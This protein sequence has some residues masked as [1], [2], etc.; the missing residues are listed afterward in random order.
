MS[1]LRLRWLAC[2]PIVA[3]LTATACEESGIVIGKKPGQSQDGSGG[4][5]APAPPTPEP[6]T[7]DDGGPPIADPGEP[8][9]PVTGCEEL[10]WVGE[11][12]EVDGNGGPIRGPG[13][14]PLSSGGI[15]VTYA[16]YA[17][18]QF[19]KAII[20][21]TIAE[22]FGAWP[23]V[24]G[25]QT[26][27]LT[28]F[29]FDDSL[30][31][32][33]ATPQGVFARSGLVEGVFAVGE[34]GV[35]V[36]TTGSVGAMVDE[37][38]SGSAYSVRW[39][40]NAALYAIDRYASPGQA[41]E[42]ELLGTVPPGAPPAGHAEFRFATNGANTTLIS[43]APT[44]GAASL[45]PPVDA[46][47]HFYRAQGG[48][49][50]ET[51]HIDLG[52]YPTRHWLVPREGGFFAAVSHPSNT[53]GSGAGVIAVYR[54]DHDGKQVGAPWVYRAPPP[55][56]AW[57]FTGW[58]NGFAIGLQQGSRLHIVVSDG[59]GVTHLMTDEIWVFAD[60]EPYIPIVVGGDD[61]ES[62]LIGQSTTI[63]LL[64]H[65]ADCIASEN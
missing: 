24:I 37:A 63:R 8:I 5:G 16:D 45:D 41:A 65:R 27:H 46:Q 48:S 44:S 43:A 38:G 60:P 57:S 61:Q 30:G 4:D 10:A 7:N 29:D 56:D 25:A 1:T 9:A 19:V 21:R 51:S 17:P 49:I 28:G 36:R 62:I 58:R 47:L 55:T 39:D 64:L 32:I 54:I 18:D 14:F 20:S 11:P 59:V 34:P 15:G 53:N 3:A 23:P 33:T 13:L 26:V 2:A 50:M 40:A 22:P 31:V 35:L 42:P 12:V 6:E 52:F